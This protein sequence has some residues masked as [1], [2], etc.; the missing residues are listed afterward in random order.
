MLSRKDVQGNYK[1][2][3]NISHVI[4]DKRT[5]QTLV[6]TV[7]VGLMLADRD[8]LEESL[9]AF[10]ET[11]RGRYLNKLLGSTKT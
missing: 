11:R 2:L 5:Y 4:L 1:T 6:A 3:A 9:Y 7:A 8:C 10:F